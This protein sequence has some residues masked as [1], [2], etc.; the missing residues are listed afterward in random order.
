MSS[1]TERPPDAE[2]SE[3]KKDRLRKPYGKPQLKELGDLRT[4]TLG[5][6]EGGSFDSPPAPGFEWSYP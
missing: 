1:D 5:S 6:S 3:A 2:S 4:A